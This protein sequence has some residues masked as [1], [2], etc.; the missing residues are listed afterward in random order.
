MIIE[1]ALVLT[2]GFTAP[3]AS[4]AGVSFSGD[5][6][7]TADYPVIV[8]TNGTTTPTVIGS[9]TAFQSCAASNQCLSYNTSTHVFGCNASI[10]A[11]T[12]S[13]ATSATSATTATTANGLSCSG[14]VSNGA[15]ANSY[16]GVGACGAGT[17]ASTLNVNAAP[18]C[19]TPTLSP[20]G[21][22]GDM[23][24][25]NGTM[26]GCSNF[27]CD[28][29]HSRYVGV[30]SYPA[31]GTNDL[32]FTFSR[33]ANL[34]TV[35]FLRGTNWGIPM[36]T[37]LMGAYLWSDGADGEGTWFVTGA[38]AQNFGTSTIFAINQAAPTTV[39]TLGTVAWN[40]ATYRQRQPFITASTATAN[41]NLSVEFRSAIDQCWRGNATGA[42]GCFYWTRFF[43]NSAS[44]KQQI[45]VGLA[46]TTAT[47]TAGN[48]PSAQ[49]DTFYV[50]CDTGGTTLNVCSNDNAGPATCADLGVNFPTQTANA[51]YDVTL[52]IP[53]NGATLYYDVERYDSRFSANGS[54]ASDLPRNTVQLNW[55][56]YMDTADGGVITSLGWNASVLVTN[57]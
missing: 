7:V 29:T 22:S 38:R 14:C 27:E 24:Y 11:N 42:G 54:V 53:P 19:T 8:Q 2:L 10:S 26:G 33:S 44:T 17:F 6:S 23:Q 47:F 41:S 37:G 31:T 1:L 48:Q 35:P 45:F 52:F 28:G 15:L 25:N 5:T 20:A 12:A 34:P 36:P 57:Y 32:A 46:D 21:S 56:D 16:S 13:T 39:G 30:T 3:T 51:L 9:L 55:H 50:G 43:V 4:P 18:T 49:L 40:T